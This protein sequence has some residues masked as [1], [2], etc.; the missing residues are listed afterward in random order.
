MLLDFSIYVVVVM[1][2]T[3]N[4]YLIMF[5]K[6]LNKKDNRLPIV[7]SEFTEHVSFLIIVFQL[8]K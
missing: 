5:F 1:E 7:V 2:F 4:V 3:V 6:L 8:I